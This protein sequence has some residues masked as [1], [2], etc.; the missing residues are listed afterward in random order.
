ML[1]QTADVFT[2]SF[3]LV[4]RN[5]FAFLPVLFVA[6]IVLTLGWLLG[7]ILG[8]IVKQLVD[9]LKVDN[10]IKSAG[11]D[12]IANRSGFK[13]SAGGLLGW[14]VKW[15]VITVSFVTALEILGLTQVTD[16]M[17]STV[18]MFVPKVIVAVL[19][20]LVAVVLAEFVRDVIIGAARTAGIHGANFLGSLAKW[21]IWIFAFIAALGQ[22]DVATAFLQTLFGGFVIAVSLAFG[23]AFGLG[24]RDAAADFIQKMKREVKSDRD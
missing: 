16:F 2:Q 4:W 3:V 21:A 6:L 13:F 5:F 10:V 23:L 24:G 18:L 11:I 9:T 7:A 8:K 22:L 19:I 20:L 15:L 12:E 17:Y 1:M 14:L